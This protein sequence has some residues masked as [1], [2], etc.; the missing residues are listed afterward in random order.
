VRTS[1]GG[2]ATESAR[3]PEVV[4]LAL[5]VTLMV[6]SH[7]V[8][9][10]P[11]FRARLIDRLGRAGFL[12][13]YGTLSVI[14]LLW[15]IMAFR[16]A[17]PGP[18]LYAPPDGGRALAVLVMPLATILVIGRLLQRPGEA[19]RGVYRITT[20]P[21]SLG[22]LLWALLHLINL[23][24]ARHVILFGGM[25]LIALI[26]LVKNARLAPPGR[27]HVGIVPFLAVVL[28]DE[29]LVLREIAPPALVG[30]VAYAGLLW[31]HPPIIGR[32][33]MAGIW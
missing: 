5:A 28:G 8:P 14:V 12:I 23:G 21:G 25:A 13:A 4:E 7:A 29:R 32:D 10:A 17:D 2:T 30:L 19:A 1:S 20:V 26:A 31:L 3:P 6:L 15:V 27:R 16:R 11:P 18:W 33:P 24:S 9:S 22:V